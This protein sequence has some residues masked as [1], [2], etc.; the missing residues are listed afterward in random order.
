MSGIDEVAPLRVSSAFGGLHNAHLLFL[1][2]VVECS[3]TR[4]TYTL[5]H[6]AELQLETQTVD[7]KPKS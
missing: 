5:N 4:V 1:R 2:Y 6:R 7:M 3:A